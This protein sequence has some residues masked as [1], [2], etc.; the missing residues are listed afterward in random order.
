MARLNINI[1]IIGC[2]KVGK[3]LGS[4]LIREKLVNICGIVNSNIENAR[5][6]VEYFGEG[7]AYSSILELPAANLYFILTRDDL[8]ECIAN[9]L[10]ANPFLSPRSIIVHCSGSLSSDVLNILKRKDCF[11]ASIH[12]IKSF[13]DPEQSIATFA[14]TFCAMEGD[15]EILEFLSNFFQ[16]I[17]S[18][19]FFID[20]EYKKIYHLA[21]VLCSNFLITLHAHA[22]ELYKQSG[23][24]EETAKE[25]ISNLM[26]NSLINLENLSHKD[27]L[28]GPIQRG[29]VKTVN[30]HVVALNDF[31]FNLETKNIYLSLGLGTLFLTNH[32][33]DKKN[34]FRKILSE[35]SDMSR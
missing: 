3:T 18:R 19:T 25:L 22:L 31:S 1:N 13:A 28:T 24:A 7:K 29:D 8:I 27:A 32:A 16:K 11:V 23:I 20:K 26:Y 33:E 2:G 21:G 15:K 17:G 5:K 14:G 9:K 4:L 10:A 34:E 30:D 35:N 12:P 6:V